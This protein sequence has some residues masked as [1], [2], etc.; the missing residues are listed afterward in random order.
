MR[1]TAPARTFVV[2]G[3]P[4]ASDAMRLAID[5]ELGWRDVRVPQ[6]GETVAL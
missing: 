3:D 1:G 5:R 2:H 6:H 4:D